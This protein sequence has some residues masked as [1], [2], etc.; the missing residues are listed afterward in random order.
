MLRWKSNAKPVHTLSYDG[1][2]DS[3]GA[4]PTLRCDEVTLT[5]KISP[6]AI[7]SQPAIL[8]DSYQG[9]TCIAASKWRRILKSPCRCGRRRDRLMIDGRRR[10]FDCR[11][12]CSREQRSALSQQSTCLPAVTRYLAEMLGGTSFACLGTAIAAREWQPCSYRLKFPLP[13]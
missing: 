8:S 11:C 12:R 6:P 4:R 3:S 10:Y 1:I 9:I 7:V 5:R 13:S 2:V